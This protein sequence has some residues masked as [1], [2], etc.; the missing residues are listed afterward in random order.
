MS[1]LHNSDHNDL[2]SSVKISCLPPDFNIK[3][4]KTIVNEATNGLNLNSI[5]LNI[6]VK[7]WGAYINLRGDKTAKDLV[8]CLNNF[9]Y[10]GAKINA[11]V[12]KSMNS[13]VKTPTNDLVEHCK[14][15]KTNLRNSTLMLFGISFEV[16]DILEKQ[17]PTKEQ[18]KLLFETYIS[19]IKKQDGYEKI[20]SALKSNSLRELLE[21]DNNDDFSWF[22][23]IND[24]IEPSGKKVINS[25]VEQNDVGKITYINY[26]NCSNCKFQ[27]ASFNK[28]C[29]MCNARKLDVIGKVL[30]KVVNYVNF[31]VENCYQFNFVLNELENKKIQEISIFF[32]R[33]YYGDFWPSLVGHNLICKPEDLQLISRLLGSEFYVNQNFKIQKPHPNEFNINNPIIKFSSTFRTFIQSKRMEKKPSNPE[34]LVPCEYFKVNSFV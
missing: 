1:K 31:D 9:E 22:Y 16:Y 30:V 8:K 23:T 11:V 34:W 32:V 33:D 27:N 25:E 18:T 26:W 20:E 19:I 2:R 4:I 14:F 17:H 13:L 15:R 29:I 7:K 12:S 6:S 3:L 21:G 28:N 5:L 24:Y 10:E